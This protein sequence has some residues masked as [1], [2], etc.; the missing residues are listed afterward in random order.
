MSLTPSI[1]RTRPASTSRKPR[2]IAASSSISSGSDAIAKSSAVRIGPR[3]WLHVNASGLREEGVERVA[4]PAIVLQ[5]LPH[6]FQSAGGFSG[7]RPPLSKHLPEIFCKLRS[8]PST[9]R[10]NPHNRAERT[11]LE[12]NHP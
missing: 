8:S 4:L 7:I 5:D 10:Y 1:G 11:Y 9:P 12:G 3:L 6:R 2:P